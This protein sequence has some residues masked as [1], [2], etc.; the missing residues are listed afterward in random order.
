MRNYVYYNRN[1]N[2]D[3]DIDCVTRAISTAFEIP[4]DD[5]AEMLEKYGY[6]HYC[7]ELE[8]D[9]YSK[10]LER[11]FHILPQDA[12]GEKI[13]EVAIDHLND[14]LLI[15]T[16]GHLTC[17]INGMVYDIWNCTDKIADRYWIV[18]LKS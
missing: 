6:Q 11:K 5:V 18:D 15:R 12:H 3:I 7:E 10:M 1:P 16:D 2:G 17:S 4:Y 13:G 14:R 8:V 9:C